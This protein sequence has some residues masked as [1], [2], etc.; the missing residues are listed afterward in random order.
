M[1]LRAVIFTACLV[2]SSLQAAHIIGGDVT[3]QCLSTNTF[4]QSTTFK[5]TFTMYRDPFGGGAQFDTGAEFGL[6]KTSDGQAWEHVQT[7]EANPTNITSLEFNLACVVLP[8]NIGVQRAYYVFNAEIPWGTENYQIVYQRCC[9]NGS[10]NNIVN[11]GETGAAFYVDISSEAIMNCNNS[12]VFKNFPPILICNGKPLNFDHNAIDSDGDQLVYEFC[13]PLTAGGTVGVMGGDPTV[14]NGVRPNPDNCPPP[15]EEVTFISGFY[16]GTNPMGGSPQVGINQSSGLIT[17]IPDQNGQYVVGVCVKEYR[18][19]VL[20]GTIRRDFQFNVTDCQGPSESINKNLCAGDSIII[21]D[22]TYY[23]SGHYTQTFTTT[24]GCDSTLNIEITEIENAF[25]SVGYEIC[26]GKSVILNNVI[27]DTIGVF[28]QHL[29]SVN[30]CDSTLKIEINYLPEKKDSVSYTICEGST[31]DVNGNIYSSAGTYTQALTTSEGC[32]SILTI[33]ILVAPVS[34]TMLNFSL[35]QNNTITVNNETYTDEGQYTQHLTS[36]QGCDSTLIINV[37]GCDKTFSFDFENC[38]A[39]VPSASMVYEEF[40]PIYAGNSSCGSVTSTNVFRDNPNM[41]KH[42]CTEGRNGS[43]AMCVSSSTSCNVNNNGVTPIAFEF[44]INPENGYDLAFSKLVFHQK[45]PENY[46]WIAGNSGQNNYPTRYQI[47]VLKNNVEIYNLSDIP[48]SLT[49]QQELYDFI[50]DEAFIAKNSTTFRVE[51]FPY[52]A[53]G[54]SSTVSAWDIDDVEVFT[55]CINDGS[56]KISGK[57]ESNFSGKTDS[58]VWAFDG[59]NYEIT[60]VLNDGTFTFE[61]LLSDK[62]YKIEIK[63]HSD[64]KNGLNALDLVL[65]QRHILGMAPFQSF[66]QYHA[67]DVTNDQRITVTDMVEI[68]KIILGL[69]NKFSNSDSYRFLNSEDLN[70]KSNPWEVSHHYTI[71]P[72]LINI[73]NLRFTCIKVGNVD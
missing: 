70:T 46:A 19:G 67:A 59:N 29:I 63:Q 69:S 50:G 21:N 44:I 73:E 17:G 39:L 55:A 12:P 58:K 10:I 36:Q 43:T 32:D 4:T 30:G 26:A 16:S 37:S 33:N 64:S 66:I 22:S 65:I 42:S 2:T 11:P 49:W 7:Y 40:I 34:E 28:F 31:I 68:R 13:S 27:Y 35:C 62:E 20:I 1:I 71:K 61:N 48:T 52:C 5:I 9:R 60:N 25:A 41:N 15:F 18:N 45:A 72:G 14:C 38:D 51:L 23:S 53:V 54:N 57:I 47:R 3:Y 24:E 6:Y 56:R 8:P